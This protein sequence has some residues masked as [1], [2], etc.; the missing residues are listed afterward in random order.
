MKQIKMLETHTGSQDGIFVE[1]FKKGEVYNISDSLAEIFIKEKVAK[2]FNFEKDAKLLS[3]E[4]DAKVYEEK[5][6]EETE[7]KVI[8]KYENK[9]K[10]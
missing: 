8:K 4:K 2:L 9:K 10:R 3:F 7:N 6:A 5:T 1:E